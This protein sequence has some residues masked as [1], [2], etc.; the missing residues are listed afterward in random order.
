[1]KKHQ[2]RSPNLHIDKMA[3]DWIQFRLKTGDGSAVFDV[4]VPNDSLSDAQ[5]KSQGLGKL[6]RILDELHDI[7]KDDNSPKLI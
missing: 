6:R 7:M 2:D 1:M 3:G 4:T 5:R